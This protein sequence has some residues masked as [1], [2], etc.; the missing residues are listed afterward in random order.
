MTDERRGDPDLG[1]ALTFVRAIF[2]LSQA[3]LAR[4]ARV[5][6]GA[7][8]DYELGKTMPSPRTLQRIA[9]ALGLPVEVFGPVASLSRSL[10]TLSE[11]DQE[12]DDPEAA[13]D[14]DADPDADAEVDAEADANLAAAVSAAVLSAL[15][16]ARAELRS[17]AEPPRRKV[18]PPAAEDRLEVR[19]LWSRFGSLSLSDRRILVT[20]VAELQ[21]WALVELLCAESAQEAAAHPERACELADLALLAAVRVPGEPAWRARVEAHAWAHVGIARRAQGDQPGAKE[22]FA[23]ARE[24]KSGEPP[25]DRHLLEEAR[26]PD[27]ENPA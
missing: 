20:N 13:W 19:R 26:L 14:A 17:L 18:T 5:S 24:L 23:R 8:S 11:S 1:A 15:T 10:R 16:A 22:A 7:I 12:L 3:E 27:L 6:P 2:R 4:R 21:S 9:D 25:A